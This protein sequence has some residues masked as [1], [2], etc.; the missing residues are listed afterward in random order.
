MA[1]GVNYNYFNLEK[2]VA[3]ARE[4]Y[5]LKMALCKEKEDVADGDVLRSQ[6]DA[7]MTLLNQLDNL[8]L[9]DWALYKDYLKKFDLD[10]LFN[11]F[12]L[13]ISPSLNAT[14][15]DYDVIL[16]FIFGSF[17]CNYD[18]VYDK[19]TNQ[20]VMYITV[21][22]RIEEKTVKLD[23][24]FDLTFEP[25]FNIYFNEQIRIEAECQ[26]SETS[27]RITERERKEKLLLFERK[28]RRLQA[29]KE[30]SEM[31]EDKY[32]YF[33]LHEL[34]KTKREL[35]EA[36]IEELNKKEKKT[37]ADYD[38]LHTFKAV[39]LNLDSISDDMDIE[40]CP[41]YQNYLKKFDVPRLLQ[42]HKLRRIRDME[43]TPA[44]NEVL[45][46]FIF[47]SE[48]VNYDIVYDKDSKQ[49]IVKILIKRNNEP[50]VCKFEELDSIQISG[51][52]DYFFYEQV[53]MEARHSFSEKEKMYVDN[54]RRQMLQLFDKKLQ[55][56]QD[57]K[58][59]LEMID[60]LDDLYNN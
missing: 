48:E 60:D 7:A 59:S 33:R 13:R 31:E 18:L 49:V 15:A 14:S 19:D 25:L 1:T 16:R 43:A 56:L 20:V 42:N 38:R 17:S 2:C 50:L 44:D 52:F 41:F 36:I 22:N 46:R 6:I 40:D 27:K 23:E 10:S 29:D 55:I 58:E 47:G 39:K 34:V 37:K 24:L 8:D 21:R 57:Y 4:E 30:N 51:L 54:T 35:T 3:L 12:E 28:M 11:H 9:E 53:A 5:R 45:L 32:Y 26:S